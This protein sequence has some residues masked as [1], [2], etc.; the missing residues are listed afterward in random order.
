MAD[1]PPLL[2]ECETRLQ[3][4]VEKGEIKRQIADAYLPDKDR[5]LEWLVWFF[6]GQALVRM[7]NARGF[8][9]DYST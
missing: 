6:D 4:R 7:A 5:L 8:G 3:A 1:Y 2:K 9:G